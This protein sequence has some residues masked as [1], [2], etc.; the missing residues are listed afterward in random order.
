M[1]LFFVTSCV[2]AKNFEIGGSISTSSI[3]WNYLNWAIPQEQNLQISLYGLEFRMRLLDS[4]P[5][6]S[7]LYFQYG[8]QNVLTW[9]EPIPITIDNLDFTHMNTRKDIS[10]LSIKIPV[11]YSFTLSDFLRINPGINFGW[12]KFKFE[13]SSEMILSSGVKWTEA[14]DL[15]VL[16][17][18]F[19]EPFIE[20]DIR[21]LSYVS[22]LLGCSYRQTEYAV[23]SVRKTSALDL[24][25]YTERYEFDLS[26][27]YYNAAIRIIL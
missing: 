18:Y 21:L 20:C 16:E 25:F 11:Y 23:N 4:I 19:I 1:I 24:K 5:I 22:I 13:N 9:R 17:N 6:G 26:G 8:T 27:F 10:I 3:S 15:V 12:N 2:Y 14:N 7:G